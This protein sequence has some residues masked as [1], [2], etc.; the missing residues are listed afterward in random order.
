[1]PY[2]PKQRKRK[3]GKTSNGEINS[4]Q[5]L[6]VA[7]SYFAGGA[8]H[9][10]MSSHGIGYNDVYNS[11]WDIVDAIN[12]CVKLRIKFPSQ[13]EQKRIA[14]SFARKSSVG[15]DNCVG[16]IDGILAWMNKATKKTLQVSDSRL[17][18]KKISVAERKGLHLICKPFVITDAVLWTLK[19]HIQQ[20]LL[21]ILHLLIHIY[22]LV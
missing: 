20:A 9:D 6:S 4:S 13:D 8:P 11:I 7:I 1:M 2:L 5:K 18:E 12:L 10:L 14:S 19:Y 3:R 17:G 15:F 22:T 21:T 16:C